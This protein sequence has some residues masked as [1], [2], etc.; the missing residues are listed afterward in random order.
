MSISAV[1]PHLLRD[2][3]K[4]AGTADSLLTF[5]NLPQLQENSTI[6]LIVSFNFSTEQDGLILWYGKVG[7]TVPTRRV[8]AYIGAL[9]HSKNGLI[10]VVLLSQSSQFS[11]KFVSRTMARGIINGSIVA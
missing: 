9:Y 10:A 1:V 6:N 4:M 7:T 5:T 8:I 11:L 2:G 3:F